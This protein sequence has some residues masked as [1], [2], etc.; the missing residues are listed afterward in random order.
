L[1]AH[2]L[3]EPGGTRVRV[4]L[5]AD[6]GRDEKAPAEL[7]VGYFLR[8]PGGAIAGQAFETVEVQPTDHKVFYYSTVL[9]VPPGEYLLRLA[10][11]DAS[12]RAGVVEVPV[13][14]QFETSAGTEISDVL[15]IEPDVR[16]GDKIK[17]NV[18]GRVSGRELSV[19]V[20]L[21]TPVRPAT[22]SGAVPAEPNPTQAPVEEPAAA[23]TVRF[24]V[25]NPADGTAMVG[26]QVKATAESDKGRWFAETTL[27]IS[28]LA[29]GRYTLRVAPVDPVTG[30][31]TKG[32]TRTLHIRRFGADGAAPSTP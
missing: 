31:A 8:A 32:M 22:A 10:A 17:M 29:A 21:R 26:R 4:L 2:A 13:T 23:P 19:Y 24:D 6:L 25:I 27:N 16:A 28:S 15:L 18:D 3:G 14:A 5:A 7:S 12:D 11:V 30:E 9:M 20:E 1:R